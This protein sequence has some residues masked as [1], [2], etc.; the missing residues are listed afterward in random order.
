[1]RRALLTSL[2]LWLVA[3]AEDERK[4]SQTPIDTT[5]QADMTSDQASTPDQDPSGQALELEVGQRRLTSLDEDCEGVQ[6]LNG[7]AILKHKLEASTHQLR[8]IS[9]INDEVVYSE[10]VELTLSVSWPQQPTLMCYPAYQDERGRALAPARLAMLGL[11][12]RVKT[13]DGRFD[14]VVPAR[15]WVR[16]QSNGAFAPVNIQA[17]Q[18]KG[19]L[20]GSYD[21]RA[22]YGPRLQVEAMWGY[23]YSIQSFRGDASSPAINAL[24]LNAIRFYLADL[25]TGQ[26]ALASGQ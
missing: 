14:E 8:Y 18:A 13:P 2:S 9:V 6:G 26:A 16:R 11:T 15:A 22:Q 4:T 5:P 3:C 1:M 20:Q 7:A 12:L 25:P 23:A 10:P 24:D 17:T 21:P 19:S